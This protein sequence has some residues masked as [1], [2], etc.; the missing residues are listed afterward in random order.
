MRVAECLVGDQGRADSRDQ[1]QRHEGG[2]LSGERKQPEQHDRAI[3]DRAP[4][5]RDGRIEPGRVFDRV[6][7]LDEV[8]DCYR[9]MN[10]REAIKGM[11]QL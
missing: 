8:P 6:V 9:A 1:P 5:R 4:V 3:G 11:V 10:E 7:R 2:H